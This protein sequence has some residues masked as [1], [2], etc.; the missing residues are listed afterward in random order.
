MLRRITLLERLAQ[1]RKPDA[2]TTNEDRVAILRSVMKN[3]QQILNTRQGSAAAQMDL[4]IPSPHEL[5]QG[6]PVTQDRAQQVIRRSIMA[7]E[8]RLANVIV[9]YDKQEDK[10]MDMRFQVTAQLAGGNQRDPI[11]F[12]TAVTQDG[13][14]RLNER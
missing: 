10:A 9:R 12:T 11:S 4:G 13:R 8:P 1:A 2:R 7:Y 5:L 3:L 6:F 14:V